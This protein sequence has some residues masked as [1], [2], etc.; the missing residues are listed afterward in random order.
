MPEE[1]VGHFGDATAL[2]KV[3]LVLLSAVMIVIGVYPTIIVTVVESGVENIMRLMG[4][5]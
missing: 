2:D 5:A 3:A 1:F 4:G